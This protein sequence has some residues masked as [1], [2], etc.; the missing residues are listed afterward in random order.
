MVRHYV[1][2]I[3][4]AAVSLLLLGLGACAPPTSLEY[5][6][7]AQARQSHIRV[8][9]ERPV[10]QR[11]YRVEYPGGTR[12]LYGDDNFNVG[13]LEILED[14]LATQLSPGPD[15]YTIA[16]ESL[17]LS[18]YNAAGSAPPPPGGYA[19]GLATQ[20]PGAAMALEQP[21]AALFE[22][23]GGRSVWCDLEVLVDGQRLKAGPANYVRASQ[24]E[25]AILG[26]YIEAID[27]I[28]KQIEDTRSGK[29]VGKVR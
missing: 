16:V 26:T 17:V 11:R 28:A 20:Y 6:P 25:S 18:V 27:S 14:R 1:N 8:I 7:E 21:V 9:D 4:V 12:Y 3:R 5:R 15:P 13:L 19:L 24:L 2:G 22:E 10:E 23:S 29:A